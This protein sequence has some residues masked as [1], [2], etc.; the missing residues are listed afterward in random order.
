MRLL[1]FISLCLSLAIASL[2]AKNSEFSQNRDLPPLRLAA[3]DLDTILHKTHALVL[4]PMALQ[5][6]KPPPGRV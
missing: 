2:F 5:P 4:R 3:T 6:K 1:V